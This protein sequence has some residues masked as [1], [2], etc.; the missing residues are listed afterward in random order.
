MMIARSWVLTAVCLMFL[1]TAQWEYAATLSPRLN[2]DI[3]VTA[4]PVY[5]ALAELGGGERFPRGA[6]L[7][8]VHNGAAAPLLRDFAATADADVS[9]DGKSV[10]F[11]GRKIAS[12]CW[13]IWELT[14]SDRS[15]RRVI[16]SQNDAE[17]PFYLPGGRIIWAQRTPKGFR[18]ASDN[19]GR[20]PTQQFLNPTAG[21]GELSLTYTNGSAFPVD[22][23]ADG[24][25]LF[26]SVFPLGS[27][28]IP[29]LY[30]TYAD[31]SGVESYRC[32]HGRARWG[33]KQLSSGDVVFTH[34]TSLARFSSPY[35]HE[36]P[37][38]APKGEYSGA[39]V[40]MQP[41]IWLVS[42]RLGGATRYAL[43]LWKPGASTM[44]SVLAGRNEDIVEPVL[45]TVRAR[46]NRHPSGLHPWDY[47][48]ILALDAR[49]SRA[50]DLKSVPT[51]VQLE[52]QNENG[53][54]VPMGTAPVEQ[55]GSFYVK[56]AADKPI[57][58]ALL[59]AKGSVLRRER[60]WFW[61]RKGEQRICVGCHTG[62]ERASEN[63]VP[64]V[65]L[66]STTPFD[67]TGQASPEVAQ[68]K[69]Q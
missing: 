54:T 1:W 18:I 2:T 21:P 5:D 62:P 68:R 27:G 17:R 58:I 53:L 67:L 47:G 41:G 8:L 38:S 61:I 16:S 3:I 24:R 55:D 52:M 43:E 11:A 39:I 12:D 26:E 15:L 44:I 23:L 40:E 10:L 56:V 36:Q 6:Q 42:A 66:R 7:L 20:V 9:F 33:G 31:G 45:V 46:P 30:L 22:V 49:L 60:G 34:G 57:R 59:N 4:A 37:I 35:S 14:F 48:N 28:S 50:G 51:S 32:D 13:Q 19:D 69:G 25:I 65:L 64:A 29:E 63:R